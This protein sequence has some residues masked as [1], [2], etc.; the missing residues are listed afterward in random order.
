[1]FTRHVVKELSAY[2]DNQLSEKEKLTVEKH[3]K[4]CESCRKEL[5]GLKLISEK[6]KAIPAPDLGP[7][8]EETVKEMIRAPQGLERGEVKMKKKTWYL[9]V[10]SGILAG[11]LL[12]VFVG[13]MYMKRSLQ[14][15]IG[16]TADETG[17]SFASARN[18]SGGKDYT[19]AEGGS[20]SRGTL[21]SKASLPQNSIVHQGISAQQFESSNV[22]IAVIHANTNTVSGEDIYR[23]RYYLTAENGLDL[24]KKEAQRFAESRTAYQDNAS[25]IVIQPTLPA[26]GQGAYIIRTAEV[27][28]EVENGQD[29]YK[30]TSE[31]C[32]ELG[33]YLAASNFYEDGEG[34]Q[35]GTVTMRIPKDKFLTAL[36]K[37]SALGKV[38]GSSTQSQDVS[39][40]YAN[41]KAQMDASMVVYNKML[42]ALQKR[43]NTIPEAVRMESELTPVLQR[44]ANLK[45]KMEAL[46]N[47][48]SFTTVNLY[49]HEAAVSAKV[50][51]EAGQDIQKSM[52]AAKINA[53]RFLGRALPIGIVVI[54]LVVVLLAAGIL[55]VNLVKKLFKRG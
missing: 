5:S 15:R 46:N 54:T 41:L 11:I 16:Q 9:V 45:N 38:E 33:G 40:E 7:F 44:I 22:P 14:G 19:M 26:T 31:L 47:S 1:M 35:A 8:F 21:Y 50:L 30:K 18:Y 53:V 27:R 51:K 17:E 2:L 28:L 48:V 3:L 34:R 13:Q 36:D 29:T 37:L 12:F 6:L 23:E 42:E 49:F 24:E 20:V 43:Q 4:G 52:L 55:V 39:Q 25:V 10:P 32:Q